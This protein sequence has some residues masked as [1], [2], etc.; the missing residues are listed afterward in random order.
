MSEVTKNQRVGSPGTLK[1]TNTAALTKAK[2]NENKT[3]KNVTIKQ[4]LMA[5]YI[6]RLVA[7]SDIIRKAFFYR[8]WEKLRTPTPG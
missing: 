2:Q 3:T 6:P 8:R 4:L 7:C 5:V 1:K